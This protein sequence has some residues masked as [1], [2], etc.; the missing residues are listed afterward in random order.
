MKIICV[1]RNYAEHAAELQNDKPTEPVIFLKP[2]TALLKNNQP[3]Y[4]PNFSEEIHYECEVVVRIC[5]EGKHIDPKFSHKYYDQIGLGVDFTARDLQ[6]SLKSKGLPWELSK[7]FDNSAVVS[8][9]IPKEEF[10]NINSLN[11]KLFQNQQE[12]QNGNTTEMLF[13]MDEIISFVSK[14][15]TLKTGDYIF[16]GTPKGVGKIL[17][18][19]VLEGY[20]ENRKMF[21][22]EVK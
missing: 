22:F 14:Y 2:D 15:I 18:G 10:H 19:D 3:F 20:L 21:E 11:F 16:T 4:H 8:A 17:I 9:F 1:G 5:R 13:N 6:N 7:A 12:K